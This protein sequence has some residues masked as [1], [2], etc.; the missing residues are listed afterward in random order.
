[1]ERLTLML[2]GA[3]RAAARWLPPGRREWAE[4]VQAEAELIPAGWPRVGWLAG[5]LRLAAKEE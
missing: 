5:G 2:A 4:A 3:L 1:M